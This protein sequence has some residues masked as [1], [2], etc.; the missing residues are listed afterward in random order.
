MKALM[1]VGCPFLAP[2]VTHAIGQAY[3]YVTVNMVRVCLKK[4]PGKAAGSGLH[5]E[6]KKVTPM[7]A[8][9]FVRRT[10]LGIGDE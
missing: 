4:V 5:V 1:G 6:N 7:R 2:S 9:G 3:Y 10:L 8:I